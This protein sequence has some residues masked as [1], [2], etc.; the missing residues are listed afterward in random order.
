MRVKLPIMNR[1]PLPLGRG[2]VLPANGPCAVMG[3]LNVTPDSF[4][5]GGDLP[6][7][8]AVVAAG[9]RMKGE[10]ARVL[11]VGGESTRPG[12]EDV[13]LED[14]LSR[15]IP[16]IRALVERVGLPLSVDTRKAGVFEEAFRA[17]A[18]LL[19]D[20]SGLLWDPDMASA[21]ARTDA[22]VI[23]M[24]GRGNPK[25]M[26][27]LA[28]SGDP[29]PVV[30]AELAERVA[31]ARAAG[32]ADA[33][34]VLDPGLGFAKTAGQSLVIAHR[35]QDFHAL[36]FP[37]VVGPSRKRFLGTV[38]GHDD[39]KQRD[40]ATVAL[41]VLLAR[42]GVEMVRVHAVGPCVDGI[43]IERAVSGSLG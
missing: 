34:I 28:P 17:G 6:D 36:G 13:S 18:S 43:R 21:V 37:L 15:V 27:A 41:A 19:N 11:D 33:R 4:S 29:L 20:V 39:P 12:A 7:L 40:A 30:L 3:I 25:T 23:I 22:A 16:A 5:D 42:A 35:I 14:E 2:D 1:F 9:R 24:H 26:D 10:G 32:I 38:T 8:D 31:V